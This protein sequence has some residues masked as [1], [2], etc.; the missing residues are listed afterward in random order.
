[1]AVVFYLELAMA[2][3]VA[4]TMWLDARASCP[5]KWLLP[6]VLSLLCAMSAVGVTAWLRTSP[7]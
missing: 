7:P 1:M 4:L 6:T 5:S 3:T 2:G